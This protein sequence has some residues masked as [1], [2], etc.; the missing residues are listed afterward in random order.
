[1]TDKPNQWKIE[2]APIIC[3]DD[4]LADVINTLNHKTMYFKFTVTK[5]Q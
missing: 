5:L 3:N 4:E 1:M 2:I